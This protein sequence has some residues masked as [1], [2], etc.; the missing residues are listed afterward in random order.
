MTVH[1]TRST[2]TQ[3]DATNYVKE[4]VNILN[5]HLQEKVN[6]EF[7]VRFEDKVI[8][9]MKSIVCFDAGNSEHYLDIEMLKYFSDHFS[10][11][12]INYSILEMEVESQERFPTWNPHQPK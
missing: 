6:K 5:S 10:C 7:D 12:K 8:E 11:I 9:V 1:N 4:T 2:A 3:T